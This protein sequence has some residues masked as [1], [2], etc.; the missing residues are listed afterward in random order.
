MNRTTHIRHKSLNSDVL[1]LR[2]ET[3]CSLGKLK[4]AETE[5]VV[6]I[7]MAVSASA[8]LEVL[9]SLPP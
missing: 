6:G 5:V 3:L 9:S 7:L 1:G 2:G 4:R 8:W